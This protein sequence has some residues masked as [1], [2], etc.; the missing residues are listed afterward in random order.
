MESE[1]AEYK[2]GLTREEY[3]K[4]VEEFKA[5][6]LD[7]NGSIDSNELMQVLISHEIIRSWAKPNS[8]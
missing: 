6:D 3:D 5:I 2:F 1:K 7:N 8:G 4:A